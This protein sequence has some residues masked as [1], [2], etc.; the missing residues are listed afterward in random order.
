MGGITYRP[1]VVT[2][3]PAITSMLCMSEYHGVV[4][5]A[6]LGGH[7]YVAAKGDEV[8]GCIWAFTDGYNAFQDYLYVKP[9]FRNGRVA[10]VLGRQFEIYL[11]QLGVRRILSTM[12]SENKNVIRLALASGHLVEEGYELGY[13]E[14]L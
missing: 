2:D 14:L 7:W 10:L 8:I 13:K 3:L 11:H 1:A 4:D 12:K 9:R 5:A 6:R